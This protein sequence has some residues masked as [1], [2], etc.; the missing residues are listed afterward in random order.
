MLDQA[1]ETLQTFDWGSDPKTLN[2]IDEAIVAT[3][4]DAAKR[5]ELESRLVAVLKTEAPHAAKDFVCRKLRIVGTAASVP[6]LAALLPDKTF[7]HLARYALES[8]PAPEA[9]QA[10]RDALPKVD[11]PLKIGAMESLGTRGDVASVPALAALLGDAEPAVARSAALALGAIRDPAGARA[12]R[13]ARSES[14]EVRIAATDASLACAEALLAAGKKLEAMAIYKAFVGEG[15]PK[16]VRLA[17][18]RGMLA[19]A[20]RSE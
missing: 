2:A 10:L 6:S 17:A 4:D 8:I 9:A 3:R 15:Q 19:C 11:N 20:G 14:D 5:Q 13:E 16:H 7:S 18:T 12:L 1:F